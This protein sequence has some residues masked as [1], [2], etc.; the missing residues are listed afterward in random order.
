VLGR[1][2]EAE[3][4]LRA[5]LDGFGP[6]LPPR[7][8]IAVRAR[9]FLGEALLG[10]KRYA[11]AHRLLRAEYDELKGNGRMTRWNRRLSAT[12]LARL[13]D[14]QGLPADAQHWRA[15]ADSDQ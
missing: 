12:L 8:P 10:Q 3:R 2:A 4:I 13:H 14:A 5:T 9:I 15:A 7:G 6:S 1:P 11:E